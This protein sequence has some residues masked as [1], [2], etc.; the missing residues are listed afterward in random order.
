ME[1]NNEGAAALALAHDLVTKAFPLTAKKKTVM[2]D[3]M[4]RSEDI[5]GPFWGGVDRKDEA[6][7][8]TRLQEMADL[9]G[10]IKNRLLK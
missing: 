2:P 7:V 9:I 4:S 3:G 5:D 6:A 1:E 8:K 10:D